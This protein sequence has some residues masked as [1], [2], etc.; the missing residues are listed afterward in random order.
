[1]LQNEVRTTSLTKP[2]RLPPIGELYTNQAV[3]ACGMGIQNQQTNFV[4][5]YLQYAKLRVLSNSEA[6]RI[7]GSSAVT[8]EIMCTVG[9]SNLGNAL[10][11]TCPGD[12][13]SPILININGESTIIGI[14]SFGT[15]SCDKGDN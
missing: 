2:A 10:A 15:G 12:S 8:R 7:Y 9:S 6:E 11:S 14:V 3:T 5:V 13:G 4:S 1:M